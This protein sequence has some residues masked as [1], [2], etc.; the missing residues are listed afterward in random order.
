MTKPARPF[1]EVVTVRDLLG[2]VHA[3]QA[4]GQTRLALDALGVDE[5][6]VEGRIGHH[7]V[8]LANQGMLVLVVGDGLGNLSL[9][10]VDGEVHL[11]DAD[12][13]AVLLLTVEDDLLRC[14][15]ALVLN[16]VAGLNEHASRTGC[17]IEDNA[18][19]GFDD[20]DDCLHERGR[21]EKLA[22][23]VRLLDGEFGEKVLVD[24]T[25]D[26]A[27]GLLDL[28]AVEEAH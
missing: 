17:R 16:E 24:A 22:V 10:A 8:A 9:Q 2:F 3:R 7:E 20:V 14:V 28:L 25:E 5:V 18:V 1:P 11:C 27:G 15:A 19:V 26:I 12:G 21:R 23:V 6:D 13:V 4:E